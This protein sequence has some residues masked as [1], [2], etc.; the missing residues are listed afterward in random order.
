M[1]R[2]KSIQVSFNTTIAVL[3]S[4]TV[5]L[6][7][8]TRFRLPDYSFLRGFYW[9]WSRRGLTFGSRILSLTVPVNPGTCLKLSSMLMIKHLCDPE[10]GST[11]QCFTEHWM[12]NWI[13]SSERQLPSRLGTSLSR[14]TTYNHLLTVTI[15]FHCRTKLMNVRIKINEIRNGHLIKEVCNS[16]CH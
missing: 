12:S 14:P 13:I 16:K 8:Q 7:W 2:D 11:S 6:T 3:L 9:Q 5:I 4:L 10:R 1:C 15:D